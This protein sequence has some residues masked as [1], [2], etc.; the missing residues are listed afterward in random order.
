MHRGC[1]A[2][3]AKTRTHNEKMS[4]SR[5]YA[6]WDASLRISSLWEQATIAGTRVKLLEG[7]MLYQRGSRSD[8]FYRVHGGF[9]AATVNR[10]DGASLLLEIFG[11]GAIFGEGPT[12]AGTPRTATITAL[13]DA[14]LVGYT[15]DCLAANAESNHRLAL[16][17]IELLGAKNH[18]LVNKLARFAS[19]TPFDRLVGLLGRIA[20]TDRSPGQDT[21]VVS[22]T[23]E[24][25]ASMSGLSR[26]TVTRTLK[27]MAAEGLLSTHP[28]HV[29]IL[30]RAAI[31][32]LL[33]RD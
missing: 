13:T 19:G 27:T 28:S 5:V 31:I 33:N 25:I 15:R 1:D 24:Q 21:V 22:L 8:H 23:H 18:V 26:V 10:A 17:L 14:E 30:D 7:H 12:F 29:R 16:S 4:H 11:P 20:A 2:G 32:A 9:V 6:S 3:D